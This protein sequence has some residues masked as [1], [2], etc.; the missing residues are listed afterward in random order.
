MRKGLNLTESKEG[1]M[2]VG[3]TGGRKR[4]GET[5]QLY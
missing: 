4:R 5:M 3:G 1:H 2:E